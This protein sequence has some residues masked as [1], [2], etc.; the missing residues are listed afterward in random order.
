MLLKWQGVPRDAAKAAMWF[1]HAASL[2]H[3]ES[4]SIVGLLYFNGI[5]VPHDTAKARIWLTK[6][7][8]NGDKQSAWVLDNLAE[9]GAMRL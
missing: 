4:Q 5:G 3:V 6:A 9:R 2:G 7:A 1:E 8:G